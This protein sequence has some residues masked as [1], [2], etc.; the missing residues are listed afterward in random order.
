MEQ[1]GRAETVA[2]LRVRHGGVVGAS[3]A[4][5]GCGESDGGAEGSERVWGRWA[6]RD[7][8]PQDKGCAGTH[9]GWPGRGPRWVQAH[10]GPRRKGF[11]RWDPRHG[12]LPVAPRGDP[13]YEASLSH[14][15]VPKQSLFLA[16][17]A[18]R[19]A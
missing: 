14:W 18:E 15:E 9:T 10:L 19:G 3:A 1:Q 7:D 5:W 6:R 11:A 12:A 17:V 2:V 4:W 8:G 13:S 16:D